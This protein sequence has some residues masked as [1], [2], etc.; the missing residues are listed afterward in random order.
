MTGVRLESAQRAGAFSARQAK[1]G[2]STL[3][4]ARCWLT[5]RHTSCVAHS[6]DD[7]RHR[8]ASRN[9]YTRRGGGRRTRI[10]VAHLGNGD[11]FSATRSPSRVAWRGP[12]MRFSIAAAA[13]AAS[14]SGPR[15][16]DR[17]PR[18]P[19]RPGPP[20]ARICHFHIAFHLVQHHERALPSFRVGDAWTYVRV[21][22]RKRFNAELWWN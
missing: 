1:R 17:K 14:W 22:H 8:Q 20:L 21:R 6:A 2:R 12:R 7:A 10:P 16:R 5:T 13:A 11:R 15:T 18:D 3:L 4:A 9:S 19:D